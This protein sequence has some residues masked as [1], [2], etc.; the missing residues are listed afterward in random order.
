MIPLAYESPLKWPDSRPVTPRTGQ[1][2]DHQFSQALTLDESLNF[3]LEELK[4][5][6]AQKL[7]LSTDMSDISSERLRK[8]AGVRSGACLYMK[9]GGKQYAL[10]CD[11]WQKLEHNIYTLHLTL[12]QL[13]NVERW[14]VAPLA[15]L[16]HGMEL[17][18]IIQPGL[19]Q[20]TASPSAAEWMTA[21]GL[22]PTATLEDATAIYHRRAKTL[23]ANETALTQLN[24]I[25]EE[26]RKALVR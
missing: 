12:R 5:I 16:L 11:R 1:R 13:R 25:M 24:L 7:T 17:G 9:W 18:S 6:P 20:S 15:V 10:A 19:E 2:A 26:A 22:G 21:L 3:L 14:G 23:S 8:R 4:E